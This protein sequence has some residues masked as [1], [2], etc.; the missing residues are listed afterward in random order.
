MD[1]GHDDLDFDLQIEGSDLGSRVPISGLEVQII[2]IEGVN[3]LIWGSKWGS[4]TPD[5]LLRSPNWSS[6]WV[7]MGYFGVPIIGI[8]AISATS[9]VPIS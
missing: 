9:K 3:L 6:E 1:S 7:E 2:G 5:S 4:E 8:E